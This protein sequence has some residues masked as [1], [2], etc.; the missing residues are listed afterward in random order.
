MTNQLLLAQVLAEGFSWDYLWHW[1]H[2]P[3][4]WKAVISAFVT[5][6]ASLIAISGVVL[7]ARRAAQ[8]MEISKQGTP[9]ELTCYKEWLEVSEKYKELAGCEDVDKLSAVSE[10]YREVESSRKAALARAVWERKVF[11]F[12]PNVNAQKLLMQI[13]PSK[14][15]RI[16]NSRRDE[17]VPSSDIYVHLSFKPYLMCLS[18][19]VSLFIVCMVYLFVN[20]YNRDRDGVISSLVGFMYLLLLSPFILRFLPDGYNGALEANYCFRKIIISHGQEFEINIVS[21]SNMMAR[22]LM[23]SV[24]D[25]NYSDIVYCPWEGRNKIVVFWMK[26]A[27]YFIPGYYVKKGFKSFLNKGGS[28]WGSYK[29]ELLNGD[30]KE[31]LG[32]KDTQSPDSDTPEK[33]Q[34]VPPQG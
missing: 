16:L 7:T 23:M 4:V 31:K 17:K 20:L 12:C 33:S 14:I 5:I 6:L 32:R 11:S 18:V 25:S 15:F 29:E 22:R 34:S 1:T 26:F 8:Q 2:D 24:F 28:I 3:D 21:E 9:P 10:E 30:L 13:N 19:W 27:M